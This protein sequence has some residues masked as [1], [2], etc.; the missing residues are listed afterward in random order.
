MSWDCFGALL[1]D[2]EADATGA[3]ISMS[4]FRIIVTVYDEGAALMP[5]ASG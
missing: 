5:T 1:L 4:N 3:R 2:S